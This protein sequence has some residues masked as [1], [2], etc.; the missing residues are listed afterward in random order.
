MCKNIKCSIEQMHEVQLGL[1]K[2][3]KEFVKKME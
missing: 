1:L 3:L 2:D